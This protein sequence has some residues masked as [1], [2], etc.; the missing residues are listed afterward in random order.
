MTI[1]VGRN[2]QE[3]GINYDEAMYLLDNDIGRCI[4]ELKE[5]FKDFD[6]LPENI[7]TALIDMIFNIG[8]PRFMKFKKM[9]QA[10]KDRDFQKASEEAKDSRWCKQVGKRCDDVVEMFLVKHYHKS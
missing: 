10:V 1:G 6:R 3:N 8:K 5:I 2:I 7:Q 9:I 4:R